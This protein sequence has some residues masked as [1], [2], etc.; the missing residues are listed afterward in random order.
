MRIFYSTVESASDIFPRTYKSTWAR[1]VSK[2]K[3]VEPRGIPLE[4][5]LKLERHQRS[6]IKNGPGWIGGTFKRGGTRNDKDLSKLYLFIGDCDNNTSTQVTIPFLKERLKGMEGFIHTTYSHSLEKPKFRF[7]VPLSRPIT[8]DE[9][10]KVFTHFNNLCEN[11]LDNKGK[12]PSQLYFWP[13]C[14]PDSIELFEYEQLSGEPFNPDIAAKVRVDRIK[15]LSTINLPKKL[16]L[17]DIEEL[18]LSKRIKTIIKTGEDPHSKY[19]SRSEAIF[20]VVIALLSHGYSDEQIASICL[21]SRYAISGKIREQKDPRKYVISTLIKAKGLGFIGNTETIDSVVQELN[22]IHAVVTVGGKCLIMTEAED[23]VL[24]RRDLSLGYERDLRLLYA[25][26]K[27]M[28]DEKPTNIAD[29]WMTHESRRQY[30]RIV[31]SPEY[32]TPGCYNLW[33]GFA[34]EPKEGHCNLYLSHIHDNIA[35]GDDD[36]YKYI[37]GFMADAVQNPAKLPGVALIMRGGEGTGKGLFAREFGSL[38]GQHFIHV[39]NPSHLV[40]KFNAHLRDALLVFADEAFYAGDKS[41]QGILNAII[42]EPTRLLEHKGKD[43]ITV[44]NYSR[45]IA[46]SNHDYVVPAGPVARR[47]FVVD[48]SDKKQQD[49]AYFG[50][51]R[52]EMN[53]GGRE[54]LL[55]YLLNY[56]L[57]GFELRDFPRTAALVDQ[58]IRSL[59]SEQ[60]FWFDRLRRGELLNYSGT[61]KRSVKC[62]A[63]YEQY[64]QTAQKLGFSRRSSETLLGMALTRLC[65]DIRRVRR[66]TEEDPTKKAYY[67]VF[68]DLL[69]ARQLFE[70]M[71]NSPIEW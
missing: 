36:I 46:A 54:A 41:I 15:S 32:E 14:P 49:V 52:K 71:L 58:Q 51:I 45:L 61:W 40:G 67:Y 3:K 27:I 47:F 38:F 44:P 22:S 16:P 42:T 28:I 68:P 64:N 65:P 17:V 2:L 12:T 70:K 31:F 30:S 48:V 25:N 5:Y 1:L 33:K 63:I 7:I 26:K 56:D 4:K 69:R 59:T 21:D 57:T 9:H 66:K 8:P 19:Q 24:K 20:A 55:H 35:N 23:P 13:S 29:I 43:P 50:A 62:S 60:Q 34:V 53:N 37:I 10:I 6:K 18:K 11:T 39:T